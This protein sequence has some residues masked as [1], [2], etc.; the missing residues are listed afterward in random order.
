M[1]LAHD[2]PGRFRVRVP[3]LKGGERSAREIEARLRQVPGVCTVLANPITGSVVVEYQPAATSM[4]A[5]LRSSGLLECGGGES[6]G[7]IRA[8]RPTGA[9]LGDQALGALCEHLVEV[10]IKAAVAAFI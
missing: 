8:S 2:I 6:G 1:F 10:A 9:T 7:A 4:P 5:I 3:A